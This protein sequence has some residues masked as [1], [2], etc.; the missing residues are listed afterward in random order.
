MYVFLVLLLCFRT[1]SI[2]VKKLGRRCLAIFLFAVCNWLIDRLACDY[3]APF[4]LYY[5]HA[6]WHVCV[7]VVA[8]QTCVLFAYFH[9]SELDRTLQLAPVI[10]LWP[11]EVFGFCG[12]PYVAFAAKVDD[13]DSMV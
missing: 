3:I 11:S 6:V 7:A 13:L 2:R 5:L 10:K 9:A 12:L 1:R 8:Y 4:K